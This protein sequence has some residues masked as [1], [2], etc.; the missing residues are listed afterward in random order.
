MA[1]ATKNKQTKFLSNAAF[2]IFVNLIVKPFWIFAI[3]RK[4]QNTVGEAQYGE[5]FALFN[6][7]FLFY[8]LLDFGINNFNSRAIAQN[9][10]ALNEYVPNMLIIKSGLALVYLALCF[11]FAQ[12][13]TFQTSWLLLMCCNQILI[14]FIL[15]FRS[16]LQ[17]LH[18]FR[19][20]SFISIL[21]RLLMIIIC[22]AFLY[23]SFT[24]Q[25][26][27]IEYFIYAQTFAYSI[28]FLSS[29]FLV[30]KELKSLN[31]SFNTKLFLPILKKTYPFA[32]LGLLMSLYNRIDAVM[33]KYLLGE[34]GDA[35]AGIYAAAYR[36]LDALNMVAVLLATILLPMFARMF[37][38][39]EDVR[40]LLAFG[41]KIVYVGATVG[42]VTCFFFK[43]P[44]MQLL[45]T[46]ATTYYATIFA[47]L[48]LSFIAI[49]SVYVYGTLLTAK[50]SLKVLNLIALA[51]VV[52]NISLNYYFIPIYKALG[53]TQVTFVTQFVVAIAHVV[54]AHKILDFSYRW[55]TIFQVISFFIACCGVAFLVQQIP[56]L[57]WQFAFLLSLAL[58]AVLAFLFRL[59]KISGLLS[60]ARNVR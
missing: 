58:S 52:V 45:Y 37:Q 15:Y 1:L 54:A 55:Q 7:T 39:G 44:L 40:P 24:T 53:A 56:F 4:V 28:A 18:H 29:F 23:G 5:Y 30:A 33:I 43:M 12:F 11:L 57:R 19:T 16:N 20:D 48:I 34:A 35:E 3:D 41:A 8:V 49:S 17:G 25:I 21:D 46:E 51:G 2:L 27:R 59:V 36:L 22:A 31:F 13:Q 6:Y 50:G 32:L 42:A 60:L 38:Q 47:Y 26:F 10:D 14:S 9:R